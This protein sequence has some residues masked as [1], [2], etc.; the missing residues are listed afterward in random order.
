MSWREELIA[1]PNRNNHNCFGCSSQN[2]YGLHMEF[3]T[4]KEKVYSFLEVPAHLCGW[5]NIIHGGITSTL[6]DEIMGWS[7]IALLKKFPMTKTIQI[8]FKKP[9]Y[10]GEKLS[11]IGEI[12]E[13][14]SDRE[15]RVKGKIY[16]EK[17]ELCA[18]SEGLFA[19]FIPR[20]LQRMGVISREMSEEFQT[21]LHNEDH[22]IQK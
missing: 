15:A 2:P 9:V 19:S 3:F 14:I 12:E 8:D 10:I 4:D 7:V 21:I 1:I 17:K 20:A 22:A 18:S 11:I 16:N 5:E 6:L 13:I